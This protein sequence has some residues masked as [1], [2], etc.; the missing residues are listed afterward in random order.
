MRGSGGPVEQ[1][2]GQNW[3]S[4]E[5]DVLRHRL[6]ESGLSPAGRRNNEG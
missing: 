5:P 6:G 1:D 4:R 2:C 3:E